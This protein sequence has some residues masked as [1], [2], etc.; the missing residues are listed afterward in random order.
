MILGKKIVYSIVAKK[1][2]P[3][4]NFSPIRQPARVITGI[5]SEEKLE[6]HLAKIENLK[7]EINQIKQRIITIHLSGTETTARMPMRKLSSSRQQHEYV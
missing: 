7:N 3:G 4:P 6:N 2:E 1:T 5:E